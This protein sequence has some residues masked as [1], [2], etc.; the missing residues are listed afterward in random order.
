MQDAVGQLI[1]SPAVSTAVSFLGIALVALWLA[2]AWW[3]YLDMQ[4]RATTDLPA[5]L[6]AAWIL[7]STPALLLLS[8]PIYLLARPQQTAAQRRSSELAIALEADLV[9]AAACPACGR[10]GDPEWRRCPT[11]AT[12]LAAECDGC[13]RWSSVQLDVC[14]WCATERQV[15]E[16]AGSRSDLPGWESVGSPS[17]RVSRP[18]PLLERRAEP[19]R[20][21][22]VPARLG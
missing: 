18:S 15:L 22:Q 3:A 14:P 20:R 10:L 6:A 7:L 21:P 2:A 9:N 8:I 11:C 1:G 5:F 4:R 12:W 19:A 13:G 17:D 16:P